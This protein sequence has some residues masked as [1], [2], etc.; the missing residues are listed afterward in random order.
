MIFLHSYRS[1]ADIDFE[2]PSQPEGYYGS[3]TRDCVHQ[4]A[5][6]TQRV[7]VFHVDW[8]Q[9]LNPYIACRKDAFGVSDVIVQSSIVTG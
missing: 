8:T 4:G 1:G 3:G 7:D 5:A 9:C 2:H 6:G